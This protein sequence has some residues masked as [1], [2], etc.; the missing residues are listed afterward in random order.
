MTQKMRRNHILNKI[1]RITLGHLC[2]D[3]EVCP[4]FMLMKKKKRNFALFHVM[5]MTA[6]CLGLAWHL[7]I[8]T[9]EPSLMR[10]DS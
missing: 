2:H 10:V 4:L 3:M 9:K 5:S 6:Y 8:S 7:I 1:M